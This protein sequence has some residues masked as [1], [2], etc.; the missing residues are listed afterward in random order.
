MMSAAG[1]GGQAPTPT[2]RRE[3]P[4]TSQPLRVGIVGLQPGRSWAARAH[5]PALRAL[6][7]DFVIA[8]IANTTLAGAVQAAAA[9]DH[10]P[11]PFASVADLVA[12]PGTHKATLDA[13]SQI[14]F[15]EKRLWPEYWF[16]TI[17]HMVVSD[18]LLGTRRRRSAPR[19]MKGDRVAVRIL[20]DEEATEGAIGKGGEDGAAP[21]DE[22]VVQ[23]AGVVAG[24][25]EHHAHAEWPGFGKRPH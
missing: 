15:K 17:P 6:S 14:S 10:G 21:L 4:M 5:V 12:S 22:L 11:R 18:Q 16:F 20:C 7:A 1:A 2:I 25:P 19:R 13:I 3:D 24:D 9:L 8:G 23:H